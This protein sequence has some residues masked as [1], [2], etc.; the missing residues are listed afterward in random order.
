MLQA[1]STCSPKATENPTTS[2]KNEDK[3]SKDESTGSGKVAPNPTTSKKNED[4]GRKDESTG[5]G[6]VAPKK[7][8]RSKVGKHRQAHVR[9]AC[10]NCFAI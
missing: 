10:N 6:K 1:A 5:S 7:V 9:T 3:G 4:K 2:K 8:K